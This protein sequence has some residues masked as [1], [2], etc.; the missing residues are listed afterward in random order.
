MNKGFSLK[1]NF[2]ASHPCGRE[3]QKFGITQVV[4]GQA[5]R[6]LRTEM[7]HLSTSLM[8]NSPALS[9]VY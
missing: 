6:G 1:R 4:R 3:T 9:I 5:E 8:P 2:G 7:S